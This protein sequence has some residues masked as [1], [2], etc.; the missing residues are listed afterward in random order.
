[1]DN[2]LYDLRVLPLNATPEQKAEPLMIE[3]MTNSTTVE[4]LKRSIAKKVQ[5]PSLWR[6]IRLFYLGKELKERE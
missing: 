5:Q 4:I 2:D 3:N 6:E 1:M